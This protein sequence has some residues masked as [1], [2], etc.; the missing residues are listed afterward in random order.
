[1]RKSNAQVLLKLQ[2]EADLERKIAQDYVDIDAHEEAESHEIMARDIEAE[3]QKKTELKSVPPIPVGEVFPACVDGQHAFVKNTLK[4]PDSTAVEASLAR[5]DL[6][7]Q[8]NT[9]IT[10]LA[11]DAA[12]SISAA[13]SFE[14]MLAHQLAASHDLTMKLFDKAA[15]M[16]ITIDE[17]SQ[18]RP[19]EAQQTKNLQNIQFTRLINSAVRQM[20][21][22]QQG[23]LALNKLHNGGN[24]TVTVQHVSVGHGVKAVI[25][26]VQG[27]G[28]QKEMNSKNGDTP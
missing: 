11:V 18:P 10:A 17:C 27:G 12:N 19:K 14:K 7:L 3:I 20:S 21:V 4:S 24:Q 1:M 6:L 25:G 22:Y 8:T 5:T 9:D 26:N 15:G 2:R 28:S 23:M 16:L 13:N